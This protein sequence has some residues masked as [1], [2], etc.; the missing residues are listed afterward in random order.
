MKDLGIYELHK[1]EMKTGDLLEWRSPTLIG[2]GIRFV[3]GQMVNHSGLVLRLKE[4]EGTERYRYTTEAVGHGTVLT[5]LRRKLEH[6][7]GECY[8]YALKDEWNPRRQAIGEC[9]LKYIGIPY[10]YGS[11][12]KQL[13]ARVGV[14][15]RALF[16]SEY[17]WACYGFEGEA[18]WPGEIAKKVDIF[19][20]AVRLL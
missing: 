14:D 12:F 5:F 18:P 20:P 9:A 6:H 11:I 17:V 13:I 3:T 2:W 19:K 16:C 7:K 10:D 4:Y 1:D 15:F 8:W